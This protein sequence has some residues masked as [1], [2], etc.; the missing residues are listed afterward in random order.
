MSEQQTV[1]KRFP[2]GSLI[3]G[4]DHVSRIVVGY[5]ETPAGWVIVASDPEGLAA[6]PASE[7]RWIEAVSP[8]RSSWQQRKNGGTR[9]QEESRTMRAQEAKA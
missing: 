3:V 2:V 9:R 1:A 5:Q 8:S 6:I 7:A 4:A